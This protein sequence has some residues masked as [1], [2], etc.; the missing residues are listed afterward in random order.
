LGET[1]SAAGPSRSCCKR[2]RGLPAASPYGEDRLS[3]PRP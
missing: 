3:D 1:R 2:C